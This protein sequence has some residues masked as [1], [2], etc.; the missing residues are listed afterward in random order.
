VLRG[1]VDREAGRLRKP[2]DTAFALNQ[3]IE[4]FEPMLATQCTS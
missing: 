2:L 4:Q 3:D 1:I